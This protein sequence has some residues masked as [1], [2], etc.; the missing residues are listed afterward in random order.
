M[1]FFLTTWL[2]KHRLKKYASSRPTGFMPLGKI[3]TVLVIADG[4]EPECLKDTARLEAFF[5]GFGIVSSFI[6]TDLR[7]IGRDTIVYACG[8]NVITRRD[9]D[10]TGMPD[11]R[12][13]GHLF[14]GDYDLLISLKD[15]AGFTEKFLAVTANAGFKI[16]T[17]A[18][19]GHPF[20]LVI[21]DRQEPDGQCIGP[22]GIEKTCS[23]SE[24]IDAICNFLIK[25]V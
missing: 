6:Y 3:R 23:T 25:I 9:T 17:C 1:A 14:S 7:K 16:G 2:R 18:F 21:A 12:R 22:D 10:W 20:D 19:H 4:T 8:D 13:K 5:S 11:L 24:R 15:S